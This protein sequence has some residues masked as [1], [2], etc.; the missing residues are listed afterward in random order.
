MPTAPHA[1]DT[2]AV[3]R[4]RLCQGVIGADVEVPWCLVPISEQPTRPFVVHEAWCA[5]CA[6]L[7]YT[8]RSFRHVHLSPGVR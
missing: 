3:P 7:H 8:I 4:C 1:E 6:A 2:D 5:D